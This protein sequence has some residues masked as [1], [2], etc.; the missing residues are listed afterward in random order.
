MVNMGVSPSRGRACWPRPGPRDKTAA[1]RRRRVLGRVALRLVEL[2]EDAGEP[3]DQGIR[4]TVP[5]TQE[6]L[7]QWVA[8]SREAVARALASLRKR[9]LVTTARREIVVTDLEGLRAAAG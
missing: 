1:R 9:N 8:G 4:I 5:L 6:D 7:A 3:S 2:A